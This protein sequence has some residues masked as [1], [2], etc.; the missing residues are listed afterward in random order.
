MYTAENETRTSVQIPNLKSISAWE[1][2]GILKNLNLNIRVEGTGNTIVS[3]D[4]L[5]DTLH[6]EGTIV[7]V[8][9]KSEIISG[10]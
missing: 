4:P 10:Q 2:T 1:A 9:L 8:K 6:E 7:T 3:Q 5:P